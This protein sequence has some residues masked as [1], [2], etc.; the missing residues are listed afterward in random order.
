MCVIHFCYLLSALLPPLEY[1]LPEGLFAILF[2]AVF[3][4]PST[5]ANTWYALSSYFFDEWMF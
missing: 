1:K 3:S 5:T 2:I 4:E